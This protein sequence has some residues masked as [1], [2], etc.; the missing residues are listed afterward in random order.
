MPSM[1]LLNTKRWLLEAYISSSF[2]LFFNF[3]PVFFYRY[4]SIQVTDELKNTS[5][6]V[7]QEAKLNE[8]NSEVT[9]LWEKLM[10]L[11]VQV[12]DQLEVGE[13][14][15]TYN[16]CCSCCKNNT[17]LIENLSINRR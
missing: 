1:D 11:E 9:K 3:S 8:Y 13:I 10:S 5:D 17:F 6:Q 14:F 15:E 7:A 4:F 12:A 2:D 16:F